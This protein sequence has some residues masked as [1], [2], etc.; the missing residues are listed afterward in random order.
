MKQGHL[1][2]HSWSTWIGK[3]QKREKKQYLEKL[4]EFKK[5]ARLLDTRLL[6]KN[7]LYF[8]IPNI[9]R[10]L[11]FKKQYHIQCHLKTLN[12]QE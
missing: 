1:S 6:Y 7:Q 10:K 8:Y 11:K 12:T 3:A 4:L 5:L 2:S 9:V